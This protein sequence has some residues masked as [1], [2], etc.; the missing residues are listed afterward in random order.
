MPVRSALVLTLV[1]HGCASQPHPQVEAPKPMSSKTVVFV[2]GMYVT[3]TCWAGW[4]K[5]FEQRGYRTVAPAWPEHDPPAAAQRDKHPNAALAA[6]TLDD[7]LARYRQVIAGLPEKPILVGHSMGG[8]V[9]QLLLQE[10]LGTV[11]VAID[12]APPKGVISFKWSFLKSNWRHITGSDKTPA[13]SDEQHFRYAF[14]NTLPEAEQHQAWLSEV[15]P[16]SRR[17]G[18]GPTTKTAKIDFA[19]AR[20][21]LLMIAGEKDHIIPPALNKKNAAKYRAPNVTD[22]KEFPGRD[23]WIIAAP[24]WQEVADYALGW[25]SSQSQL[26]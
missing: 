8:L 19:K 17:V 5:H 6:L 16:E 2:H 15:V 10:G 14:V 26:R 25:I 23:H 3:P 9:V 7:V 1:L 11:G 13:I 20:P 24:G 4:Q 12:S 18:K 21:P 22:F